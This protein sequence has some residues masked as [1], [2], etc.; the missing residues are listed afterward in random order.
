MPGSLLRDHRSSPAFLQSQAAR[1]P[2]DTTGYEL[3]PPVDI[4]LDTAG[5]DLPE[6]VAIPPD[7]AGFG[8]PGPVDPPPPP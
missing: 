3:P 5:Y 2:A 1:V 8:S 6:P 4:P 7:T